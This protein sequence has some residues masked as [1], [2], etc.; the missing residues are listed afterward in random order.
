MNLF[1]KKVQKT[2]EEQIEEFLTLK[3]HLTK[4]DNVPNR[5]WLNSEKFI[6]FLPSDP[7]SRAAAEKAIQEYYRNPQLVD[8]DEMQ[9]RSRPMVNKKKKNSGIG[10][11]LENAGKGAEKVFGPVG[12]QFI[13]NAP[14]VTNDL[15][16]VGMG[17][18]R[19]GVSNAQ[20]LGNS[21]DMGMRAPT[22]N[23]GLAG[24]NPHIDMDTILGQVKEKPATKKPVKRAT[25]KTK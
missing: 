2:Q 20:R 15:S 18:M 10:D 23:D 4:D 14:N 12:D 9:L 25:R 24:I 21:V 13:K 8:A 3:Y 17:T 6:D 11:F 5:Y 7:D 16:N 19:D 22:V 1:K